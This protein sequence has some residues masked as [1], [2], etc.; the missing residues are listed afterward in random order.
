[1]WKF[2]YDRGYTM[3]PYSADYGVRTVLNVNKNTILPIIK[4]LNVV[5]GRLMCVTI[6]QSWPVD[7]NIILYY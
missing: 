6:P 3:S 5:L 2:I 7:N 1:M 4:W